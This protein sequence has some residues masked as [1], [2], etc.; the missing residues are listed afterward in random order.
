MIKHN[1]KINDDKKKENEGVVILITIQEVVF[2]WLDVLKIFIS[3]PVF[4]GPRVALHGRLRRRLSPSHRRPS[5]SL[6]PCCC[7]RPPSTQLEQCSMKATAGLVH[8]ILLPAPRTASPIRKEHHRIDGG[9]H[10]TRW[11][12]LPVVDGGSSPSPGQSAS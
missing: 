10:S 2:F 12:S 5:S 1:S 6:L 4:F 7:Q 11:R 8:P 3:F 9:L